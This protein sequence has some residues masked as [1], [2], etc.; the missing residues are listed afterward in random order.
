MINLEF[1]I[2]K[3]DKVFTDKKTQVKTIAYPF[4]FPSGDQGIVSITKLVKTDW[5][6]A[7]DL[8]N[9]KLVLK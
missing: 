1:N 9:I 2:N 6:P 7:E 5:Q 3:D 4:T 8:E